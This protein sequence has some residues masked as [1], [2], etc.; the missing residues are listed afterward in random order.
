MAPFWPRTCQALPSSARVSMFC[1]L[2]NA[3][4]LTTLRSIFWTLPSVP[5]TRSSCMTQILS[6]PCSSGYNKVPWRGRAFD[7]QDAYRQLAIAPAH[8]THSFICVYEPMHG[9][10]CYRM[11]TMPFGSSA[12]VYAFLRISLAIH[13]LGARL[14]RLPWTCFYDDFPT[15]V[16]EP[17]A[18]AATHLIKSLFTLLG[19]QVSD[20][21][22]KNPP[23]AAV[24]QALGVAFNLTR[25]VSGSSKWRTP[26]PESIS[27]LLAC[28]SF[29]QAIPSHLRRLAD[30]E[31]AYSLRTVNYPDDTIHDASHLYMSF[32]PWHQALA[33]L[34]RLSDFTALFAVSCQ[35][36]AKS[37]QQQ[38]PP[39]L[40]FFYRW[41][42]G[43]FQALHRRR[44][45]GLLWASPLSLFFWAAGSFSSYN[46]WISLHFAPR[47][48]SH[49]GGTSPLARPALRHGH[50]LLWTTKLRFILSF[51]CHATTMR[52]TSLSNTS[53][54]LSNGWPSIHGSTGSLP[55]WMLPMP[56]VEAMKLSY[57]P[58]NPRS[59]T[60]HQAFGTVYGASC[61]CKIYLL[62]RF[63]P[64]AWGSHSVLS[65]LYSHVCVC[66]FNP[67]VPPEVTSHG[68][69][70][71]RV[72][73]MGRLPAL[74]PC[75]L[76]GGPPSFRVWTL[77]SLLGS[78]PLM[79]YP[80]CWKGACAQGSLVKYCWETQA[81]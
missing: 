23:F 35:F 53:Y 44:P 54:A 50:F 19:F 45:R 62:L 78:P 2:T 21:P 30:W 46:L 42:L 5:P 12:S 66:R 20:K 15:V 43:G 9:P 28:K 3:G 74:T 81:A 69:G 14:F 73:D 61:S 79:L 58:F 10:R 34:R 80:V 32:L 22:S 13:A 8:R 38:G 31:A 55:R 59:P 16:P 33:P 56:P 39:R 27:W 18:N 24:F 47:D 7:L 48:P 41:C 72:L 51:A 76:L 70:C 57:F 11:L 63:F 60:L 67:F 1:S 75:N 49:F 36:H 17:L 26:R 77:F 65:Y 25:A 64:C 29:S 37:S 4:L 68:R 52:P 40:A 71:V 6:L